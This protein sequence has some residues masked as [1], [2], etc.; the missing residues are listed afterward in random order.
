MV[1]EALRNVERHAQARRVTLR[2]V[3]EPSADAVDRSWQLELA[4]NGVGFNPRADHPGHYGLVGLHEQ[5]EQLGATLTLDSAPGQG[6][7][8]RLRFAG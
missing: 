7:R 2:L 8:L 5:A 4:D 6:C 1:R 3:P